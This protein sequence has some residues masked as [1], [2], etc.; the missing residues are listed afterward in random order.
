M[1]HTADRK[2][3]S[4]GS[5]ATDMVIW[6]N[7][8]IGAPDAETD[9]KLLSVCY[10]ENGCLDA[11]RD[12]HGH[13]SIILGRTG[14]GKSATL[15]RLSQIEANV[16]RVEPLDLAFKHIENST[17]LQFFDEVGVNLDLFYR[18]LWRHVLV[19]EL[20]KARYALKDRNADQRWYDS[21][22]ARFK[23]NYGRERSLKYLREWGD[24]FW[25]ATETR[26]REVTSKMERELSASISA[27]ASPVEAKVGSGRKLSE[28]ERAEI[29]SRGSSVVNAI[30]MREL[31]ELL[32]VLNAEVFN[33][34]QKHYFLALDHL[35][36]EWV[37]T[38]LKSRLIR[39][40]IE[41]VRAF[42][43]LAN[44]KVVVAI[45][46]DLL[47]RVYDDT[48]DGGFQQEKYEA[49]YA[50]IHWADEELVDLLRKRVNEVFRHKYVNQEIGLEDILP[51]DRKG[52]SATH[53]IIERSFQR[54]RDVIAYLNN[55]L[56]A[57]A[58]RPRISWQVLND[59][60]EQYS[61]GR[62]KSLLDEWLGLFPSLKFVINLIDGFPETFTRSVISDTALTDMA[63][64]IAEAPP[65]DEIG[66][67]CEALFSPSGK[68]SVSD[69]A[70]ASLQ[71]LYRVGVVGVK[72]SSDSPTQWSYR[73]NE[74]LS[75]G[76][77][78]RATTFKVHKMFW[79]ALRIKV[80]YKW[81]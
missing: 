41:E 40:L 12:V 70:F 38:R 75:Q 6:R 80:A 37:S 31:A 52:K 66:R 79:R 34:P 4:A 16:V 78:K 67:L 81:E 13:R 32:E 24:K 22:L 48:R 59:A 27:S 15:V 44:V 60:E 50:R 39:A 1:K 71:L 30:Q 74:L 51:S 10:V 3:N 46:E 42:R 61:R 58:G 2:K 57:A 17:V 56:E 14:A 5:I 76:D 33:D 68:K 49:Y 23:G 8:D 69:L 28:T 9:E 54:P 63:G 53:H 47:Q 21:I 29:H 26:M 62:A 65:A 20:L 72:L 64:L 55:C 43:K 7:C 25:L 18:L 19:T 77:M 45:R 35:D 11:V 73:G 36:E